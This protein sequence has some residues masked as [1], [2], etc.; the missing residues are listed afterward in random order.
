MV[1][2]LEPDYLLALLDE[3][4]RVLRPG[5][6]IALET[7]NVA[8][9]SAFFTSYLR[10]LTHARADP[11]RDPAVRR[12]SVGL[13]RRRDPGSERRCQTAEKLLSTPASTREVD[14]R[15]TGPEGRGLLAL[16]DAFDRNV[17]RLN[18]QL[19]GPLDYVV[20][21]WRP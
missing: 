14:L 3:A 6:P 20:I 13:L 12:H 19:Y 7:I 17:E 2:H 18:L 15:R 5:S 9:W 16:A 21:A 1:E 4:F 11:P 8:S 10:D